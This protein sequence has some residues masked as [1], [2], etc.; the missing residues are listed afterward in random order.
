M[1]ATNAGK[2]RSSART[3]K[4][5]IQREP[6]SRK[7]GMYETH[8]DFP[9]KHL[10]TVARSHKFEGVDGPT[11]ESM[12]MD[13]YKEESSEG[14]P[15][16]VP[17]NHA[18]MSIS[19]AEFAKREKERHDDI[20][21]LLNPPDQPQTKREM[22]EIITGRM[23]AG[24]GYGQATHV[25]TKPSIS[26]AEATATLKMAEQ[27]EAAKAAFLRNQEGAED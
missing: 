9:N 4:V 5:P 1:R 21:G 14:A 20:E 18:L 27:N 23:S 12:L 3:P 19:H 17:P 7:L 22:E 24:S 13:G 10:V 16:L 11:V 25:A 2:R 6:R 8:P 15:F 26:L